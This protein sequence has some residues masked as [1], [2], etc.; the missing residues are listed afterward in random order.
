MKWIKSLIDLLC[1]N[2]KI[3]KFGRIRLFE[4]GK[5][6][7]TFVLL[8]SIYQFSLSRFSYPAHEIIS[9]YLF[10]FLIG[11]Y[12]CLRINIYELP[13]MLKTAFNTYIY[14]NTADKKTVSIVFHLLCL[15]VSLCLILKKMR[16][17]W[18][19]DSKFYVFFFCI[20]IPVFLLEYYVFFISIIL[21]FVLYKIL[22]LFVYFFLIIWKMS[23]DCVYLCVIFK[24]KP[25][26]LVWQHAMKFNNIIKSSEL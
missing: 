13:M 12:V 10:H 1:K 9:M 2:W 26:L 18:K 19:I 25:T 16:V 14:I 22:I 3:W 24:N 7:L 5:W 15:L 21:L 4:E 8:Y 17:K 11:F 20:L 23:L 6:F